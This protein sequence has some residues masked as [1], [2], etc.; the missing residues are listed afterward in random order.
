MIPEVTNTLNNTYELD[1]K[2]DLKE[3]YRLKPE[4][5][6]IDYSGPF[7]SDIIKSF[8]EKL[9]LFTTEDQQAGRK[10]FF[11]FIELSQNV[12]FYSNEKSRISDKKNTG[13]GSLLIG[14]KASE[15][16]FVTGNIIFLASKNTLE[17]KIKI[18]NALEKDELRKYKKEQRNLLPGS[19]GNAH[20]GLIMTALTTKKQITYEFLQLDRNRFYFTIY[21]NIQ[22]ENIKVK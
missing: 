21:V 17:R 10:L 1:F 2:P 5:I 18:I 9:K 8:A 11:T 13:A 4:E 19:N 22:K 20:I 15:Y 12:A 16:Y 7:D 3:I 6:L 14:E